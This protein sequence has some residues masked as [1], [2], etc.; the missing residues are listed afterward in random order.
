M[1]LQRCVDKVWIEPTLWLGDLQLHEESIRL[2]GILFTPSFARSKFRIFL[3]LLLDYCIR[4]L[5]FRIRS[6]AYNSH[7]ITKP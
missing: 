5:P 4:L 6:R 2:P 3:S 1:R 7:V